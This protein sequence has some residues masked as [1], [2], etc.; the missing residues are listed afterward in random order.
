MPP[1]SSS[2]RRPRAS[3]QVLITAE[4]DLR[5]VTLRDAG[6]VLEGHLEYRLEVADLETGALHR[7]DERIDL[8]IPPADRERHS[9]RGFPVT[10]EV[11]LAPGRYQARV[12]ARDATSGSVGSLSHDFDVPTA[13]GLRL[14]TPVLSDRLREPPGVGPELIARRTFPPSGDLHCRFEVYGAA[15]DA[16]TGRPA[17]RA[18]FAVQFADGRLLAASRA[19]PMTPGPDGTLGRTLGFPLGKAPPGRYELVLVVE[20]EVSGRRVE[21]REAFT[22]G[23]PDAFEGE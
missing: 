4:V 3:Q 6:G 19:T 11:A 12:V 22:V 10:R 1:L 7:R 21:A 5:A 23:D 18:G 15:R 14:S 17:V 16:T 9:R 2:G 8:K 13:E 20:D